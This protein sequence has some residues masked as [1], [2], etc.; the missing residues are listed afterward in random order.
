MIEQYKDILLKRDDKF[1]L[2]SVNGGK[3]RQC[4]YLIEHNL[5]D[6]KTKHN[7]AV[8]C[9]VSLKSPQSAIVSEVCKKYGLTC[10]ILTYK[11]RVPN[12]NLS[13]AQSNG[14]NIYGFRSGYSNVLEAYAKK[15]FPN[16]FYI[17]MGFASDDVIN[18]NTEEV[19]NLPT[20]LDYL[21]IPV[22]SAMNFISI[23]KGLVKFN[24]NP[25]N[26][27]GVYVGRKPFT[28]LEKYS[29]DF[30]NLNYK[31][32]TSPYKYSRE[33]DIENYFFDPIYEAKAYD[34]L[35]KNID[36]KKNKVLLWVIGKRNLDFKTEEI[37]YKNVI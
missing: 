21:V 7:N 12:R 26:I 29:F 31:I 5:E 33:I 2:G 9:S 19:A 36:V 14:A 34:W 1:T 37:N 24:I 4:L 11:T 28:T 6:I 30:I 20:D 16:D 18:A 27:V 10:N 13:I 32:V 15:Y 22:G 8:V 3:L 25:K 23:L 17:N 35:I